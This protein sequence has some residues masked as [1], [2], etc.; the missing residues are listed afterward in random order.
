MLLLMLLMVLLAGCGAQRYQLTTNAAGSV[1]WRLDTWT[2]EMDGC[3]FESG[4]PV[5]H[6]FPAPTKK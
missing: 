5:C 2:G 1:L 6:A 3:G 4:K